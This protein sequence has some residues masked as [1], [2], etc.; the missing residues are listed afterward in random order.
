MI[1][2]P[3]D[4]FSSYC[5][6]TKKGKVRKIRSV[7]YECCY[8]NVKPRG[9]EWKNTTDKE[10]LEWVGKQ[11]DKMVIRKGKNECWGWNGFIRP[12]GYTRI[13]FGS[14]T[15]SVGGHVVSWMIKHQRIVKD[16]EC[17]LHTCDCRVCSNPRHLYLG[18]YSDNMIDMVNRKR[19]PGIKLTVAQVKKIKTRL[20][21]GVTMARLSKD[22]NV[23]LATIYD[24]KNG[25][26]WKHVKI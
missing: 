14:R 22:Y 11:F 24:I 23:N 10:K 4:S 13:K 16:G 6:I 21:D 17:V 8:K 5:I 12:D 2:R 20:L 9:F 15:T 26:T 25:R 1:D 19:N 18:D 3:N 7:C